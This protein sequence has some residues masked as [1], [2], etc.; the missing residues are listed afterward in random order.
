MGAEIPHLCILFLQD[1]K[2][3]KRERGWP[4][5]SINIAVFNVRGYSTNEVKKVEI[6]KMFL[7]RRL[8]MCALCETML[9]GTGEVMLGEVVTDCRAWREGGREKGWPFY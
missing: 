5:K 9:K 1:L 3:E 7:R 6:G 8:D 4:P 2:S